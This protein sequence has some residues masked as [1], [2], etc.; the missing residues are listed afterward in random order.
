MC[1][2]DVVSYITMI[3][4][5]VQIEGECERVIGIFDEMVKEGGVK[6]DEVTVV[7]VMAACAAIGASSFCEWVH[8]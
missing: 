7:S 1:V 5:L 3:R 2:R 8:S 4:G 6:P